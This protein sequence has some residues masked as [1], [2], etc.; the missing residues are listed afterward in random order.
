[1]RSALSFFQTALNA[2]AYP[3][4]PAP[5][6]ASDTLIQR[7]TAQIGI[8]RRALGAGVP[9]LV[10][11][12]PPKRW[13]DICRDLLATIRT[14]LTVHR[15]LHP[16]EDN[17]D[18]AWLEAVL[19][20]EES[21]A[22][23]LLA[24]NGLSHALAP[25]VPDLYPS[26]NMHDWATKRYEALRDRVTTSRDVGYGSPRYDLCCRAEV[27]GALDVD[28]RPTLKQLETAAHLMDRYPRGYELHAA[29]FSLPLF[30]SVAGETVLLKVPASEVVPSGGVMLQ[31]RNADTVY[32]LRPI[33]CYVI[34]RDAELAGQLSELFDQLLRAAHEAERGASPTPQWIGELIERAQQE[35][36]RA[37]EGVLSL[38]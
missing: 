10:L 26:P 32:R 1:L 33:L 17:R 9:P 27:E 30:F 13:A 29:P 18:P 22:P 24:Q 23:R 31:V 14:Y 6:P 3:Q 7:A 34:E 25:E 19:R 28:S 20:V 21:A 12:Q 8:L 37:S 38:A 35:L 11:S 16:L 15:E 2:A 5:D 4:N 36:A